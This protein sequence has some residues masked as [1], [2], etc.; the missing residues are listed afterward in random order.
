MGKNNVL[1]KIV[2]FCA[3]ICLCII[4][5]NINIQAETTENFSIKVETDK[6][7]YSKNDVLSYEIIVKN[8]S[9]NRS[10]DLV[11]QDEFP[12]AVVIL[13]SDGK[14]DEQIVTWKIDELEE[15]EEIKLYLKVKMKDDI[16][17]E[18]IVKPSTPND[19][20]NSK[21]DINLPKTGEIN[22]F[23][24]I[25][26]GLVLVLIGTWI[27]KVK[28]KKSTIA[29]VL[30]LAMSISL[31]SNI[32][33]VQAATI[34]INESVSHNIKVGDEN[35][36]SNI[37]ISA[38]IIESEKEVE[39]KATR[40][41]TAVTLEWDT[42]NE[43]TYTVKKG[44]S[45]NELNTIQ[46]DVTIGTYV[47]LETD[48]KKEYYY[49]IIAYKDGKE[50]L[51]SKIVKVKTFIFTNPNKSDSD[52]NGIL[53][54]DEDIDSDNLTNKQEIEYNTDPIL[55]DTDYDGINDYDEVKI[56]K[57]NPVMEDT[58]EDGLSD[59]EEICGVTGDRN[60]FFDKYIKEKKAFDYVS[61][62]NKSDTD[63]DG[64]DD[65][66]D[67]TPNKVNDVC[68]RDLAITAQISYTDLNEKKYLQKTID[69][70][71]TNYPNKEF[72]G[73]NETYNNLLDEMKNWTVIKANNSNAL[74][75]IFDHL[76]FGA[77]ALEN[78]GR[79]IISYRGTEPVDFNG[80]WIT[81]ILTFTIGTS[82][83][84]HA[85]QKLYKAIEK[86]YPNHE[87][88]VSGHSLGGMLTQDVVYEIIQENNKSKKSKI[89]EPTRVATF[90][91]PGFAFISFWDREIK[92]KMKL[93]TNNHWVK[94][95]LTGDGLGT[96]FGVRLGKNLDP[97]ITN[98]KPLLGIGY[99]FAKVHGMDRFW[100]V[101]KR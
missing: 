15:D 60:A 37:T 84:S 47:D 3:C 48:M 93:I 49:Q 80:D 58:D 30:A 10:N 18:I 67:S 64:I 57:T 77:V 101:V 52:D 43:T 44:T 32:K 14:I 74:I 42:N 85:A 96:F 23:F 86:E 78:N 91:A 8:I 66:N 31:F 38:N 65:K 45:R 25:G 51:K 4:I 6:Q 75:D 61:K 63:Y 34:T 26:I 7:E 40:I 16:K 50:I 1:G 12:E 90:N 54:A 29:L 20:D 87:L 83:Q 24:I 81:D 89:N 33:I 41:L 88:Y 9:Q 94:Y 46:E 72:K 98:E 27:Y 71:R 70:I 68:D 76:G 13:E 21:E 22:S 99:I 17:E 53:D 56:Y 100:D 5:P 92:E 36:T 28:G 35:I 11:I 19:S 55:E 97:I 59:G 82:P 39:L 62:P 73:L 2:S 69:E 79:I 95:D